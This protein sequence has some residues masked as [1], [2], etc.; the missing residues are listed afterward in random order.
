MFEC[1]RVFGDT[2]FADQWRSQALG[3]VGV[4]KAKSSFDAQAVVV[5]RSITAIHANNDVVLDVV[6]QQAADATERANR[7]DLLV[8]NL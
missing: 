5:G 1:L 8:H 6:G 7:I 2:G 3:T 4:V